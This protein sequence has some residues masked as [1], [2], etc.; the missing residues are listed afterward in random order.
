MRAGD[1]GGLEGAS[2]GR[3]MGGEVAR[4]GDQDMAALVGCAPFL[5][6]AHARLEHLEGVEARVL[7][8]ERMGEGGKQVL[9]RMAEQEIA[10]DEPRRRAHL[11]LAVERLEQSMADLGRIARRD[12]RNVIVA[13]KDRGAPAQAHNLLAAFRTKIWTI[14][15][16]DRQSAVHYKQSEAKA[17]DLRANA[18]EISTFEKLRTGGHTLQTDFPYALRKTLFSSIYFCA[19]CV[20]RACSCAGAGS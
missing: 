15:C 10:G 5:I 17:T 7:A 14:V 1:V 9:G 18:S 20:G 4:D 19:F 8:Q 16:E 11:L 3:R 6:L 13:V 12:A 2:L